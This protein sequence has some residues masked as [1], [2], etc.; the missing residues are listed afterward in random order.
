VTEDPVTHRA[1]AIAV[2][3]ED[4]ST[5]VTFR[6]ELRSEPSDEYLAQ[7]ETDAV[8]SLKNSIKGIGLTRSIVILEEI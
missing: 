6:I 8:K 3:L 4:P 1:T 2:D 5:H 7:L